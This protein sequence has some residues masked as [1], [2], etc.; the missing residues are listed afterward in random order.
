MPR[1]QSEWNKSIERGIDTLLH[2]RPLTVSV[3]IS[4]SVLQT[5]NLAESTQSTSNSLAA[6]KAIHHARERL[7]Q[8]LVQGE[9][10]EEINY[11]PDPKVLDYIANIERYSNHKLPDK[12]T[13]CHFSYLD[14]QKVCLAAQAA[15]SIHKM[16]P[17]SGDALFFPGSTFGT[18]KSFAVSKN[19]Y[20][21]AQYLIVAIRA[22]RTTWDWM[23]NLNAEPTEYTEFGNRFKC[24]RGFLLVAQ[25]MKASVE[26]SI[27]E[28]LSTLVGPTNVIFAGHSAGAAVAQLLFTFIRT[29]PA[30]DL[31]ANVLGPNVS[32]MDCITFGGPPTSFPPLPI[33]PSCLF[34]D[35]K[36]E[37]D[38][39]TLA[40]PD[41]IE[42]LLQ[43]YVLKP[44][45]T[46]SVWA[47]PGPLYYSSG[48]QILLRDVAGEDSDE[49]HPAAFRVDHDETKSIIFGNPV[50]H[51]MSLYLKRV[52]TIRDR[53]LDV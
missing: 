24:H 10:D 1:E 13:P 43:A 6:S 22:T 23:V 48:D 16:T 47:V 9:D 19:T 25:N 38:P 12:L 17:T 35:F 5:S 21:G 42:S 51:S 36:N 53:F 15:K 29:H 4:A 14:W 28:H 31:V 41:Y 27:M 39:V 7:N 52:E 34:L 2:H 20:S 11:A 3:D 33:P 45:R 32:Q 18:F 50:R 44:P 46:S 37:G 8:T 30:A 49:E 26:K 40:Q